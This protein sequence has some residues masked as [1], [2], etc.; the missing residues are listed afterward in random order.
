MDIHYSHIINVN[1]QVEPY[2]FLREIDLL[3]TD[4]SSIYSD[5]LLLNRP[6]MLFP[7]DFKEYSEEKGERINYK[8]SQV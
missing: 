5:Y 8:I 1:A 6:S 2:T 7:F 4:Y 3:I